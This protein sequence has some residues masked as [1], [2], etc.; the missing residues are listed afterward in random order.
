MKPLLSTTRFIPIDHNFD[1]FVLNNDIE[2]TVIINDDW[3]LATKITDDSKENPRESAFNN[4]V[5]IASA[6]TAYSR[7]YMS[8]FKNNPNFKLYYSD[9]DSLFVDKY[10]NDEL[11]GQELG[12]FKLE[13]E[14]KEIVFFLGLGLPLP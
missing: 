2:D 6:I 4:S 14:F 1:D 9:T 3:I 12:Q 10:L 11:V 5:A 8:V 13:N 7:V